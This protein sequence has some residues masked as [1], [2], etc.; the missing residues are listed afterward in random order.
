MAT[1]LSTA[2]NSRRAANI[3]YVLSVIRELLTEGTEGRRSTLRD[4]YY[5]TVTLFKNQKECDSIIDD[6]ACLLCCTRE[7]LNIVAADKWEVIGN[8]SYIVEGDK[9]DCFKRS[10]LIPHFKGFGSED[11]FFDVFPCILII[12]WGY[13]DVTTRNFLNRLG[14]ELKVPV[15]GL[16][17]SDP[18][19]FH[20]FSVYKC[21]SQSMSY[22]AANLTTP[23]M[24]WLG[25]RPSDVKT[26]EIP[27][28][29][30]INL[31]DYDIY[32]CK[33]MLEE[34]NFITDH[35]HLEKELNLMLSSKKF[36]I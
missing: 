34:K 30:S 28:V 1:T 4:I 12:A 29:C 23:N 32:T 33:R 31:M 35:N 19:R 10:Q 18:F 26:Y 27:E 16:V 8:L 13:L 21:G 11:H 22:D 6:I 3:V 7:S 9:V 2:N 36:E 25:I 24:K 15:F 14:V 20:I 17:D 5:K